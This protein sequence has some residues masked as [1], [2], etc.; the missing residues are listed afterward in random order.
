MSRWMSQMQSAATR[1]RPGS[2][3]PEA[4]VALRDVHVTSSCRRLKP[5]LGMGA[6]QGPRRSAT[7]CAPRDWPK[8]C[9]PRSRAGRRRRVAQ[10]RRVDQRKRVDRGGSARLARDVGAG[11]AVTRRSRVDGGDVRVGEQP[12]GSAEDAAPGCPVLAAPPPPGTPGPTRGAAQVIGG[13]GPFQGPH[14]ERRLQPPGRTSEKSH[15]TRRGP[16]G[17][18]SPDAGGGDALHVNH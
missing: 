4:R 5:P 1:R 18:R 2:A 9:G 10:R 16:L 12:R 3:G 15:W 14:A 7:G 8:A 6:L 11:E 13:L 17:P